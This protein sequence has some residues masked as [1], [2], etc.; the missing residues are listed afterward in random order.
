MDVKDIRPT[1]RATQGVRVMKP[2]EGA[3]VASIAPVIEGEEL[4]D[5]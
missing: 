1:G 3:K 4:S 5:T 2:G